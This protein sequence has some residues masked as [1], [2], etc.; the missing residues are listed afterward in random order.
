MELFAEL[1]PETDPQRSGSV[2]LNKTHLQKDFPEIIA[3]H[4]GEIRKPINPWSEPRCHTQGSCHE[5]A[6]GSAERVPNHFWK[7]GGIHWQMKQFFTI[8]CLCYFKN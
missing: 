1:C 2:V 7:I 6:S 5:R 3:G 8:K 4:G